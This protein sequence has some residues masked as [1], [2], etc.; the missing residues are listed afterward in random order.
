MT[1]ATSRDR[2]REFRQHARGRSSP[3]WPFST[4]RNVGW[5]S[6][7]RGMFGCILNH[8]KLPHCGSAQLAEP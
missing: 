1:R 7:L 6:C 3:T 8:G 5:L 2:K 4:L